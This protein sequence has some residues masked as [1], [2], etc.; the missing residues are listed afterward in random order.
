MH[1]A[2]DRTNDLARLWWT[3]LRLSADT[4]Q[5]V[6]MRMMGLSGVW[7]M[8]RGEH[9][10]MIREKAPAFTEALVAGALTAWSGRGP[11]RVMQ[12]VIEPISETARANRARLA[13]QGPRLFAPVPAMPAPVLTS[14]P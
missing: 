2:I 11:G 12:A 6:T 4:H 14:T 9:H 7:S 3:V 5:V 1:A 8:P 10:D 13:R